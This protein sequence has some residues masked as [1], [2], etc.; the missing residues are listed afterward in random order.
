MARELILID[1][2]NQGEALPFE[3]TIS[4]HAD[5]IVDVFV[6]SLREWFIRNPIYTYVPR[7]DSFG[8]DFEL[9]NIVIVDKYTEEALFLPCIT[10]NFNGGTTKWLQF[11]H[12]PFNTVLKYQMNKDGSVKRDSAGRPI[13]SHYEYT[14]S[15]ETSITFNISTQDTL[16]REELTNYVTVALSEVCRDDLMLRGIFIRGVNAGSQ[17]EVEYRE[18]HIFQVAITAEL[19]TEWKRMIPLG[20]TLKSIGFDMNVIDSNPEPEAPTEAVEELPIYTLENEFYVVDSISQEPIIPELQ[21]SAMNIEAPI[22]LIYNPSTSRWEVSS[23]WKQALMQSMIPYG[24]FIIELTKGSASAEYLQYA[25]DAI[26]KAE[27]LRALSSTQGRALPDGTKVLQDCFIFTD[28]TVDIRLKQKGNSKFASAVV[29]S[30]NDVILKMIPT[31]KQRNVLIAKNVVVDAYGVVTGGQIFKRITTN[32]TIN[33]IQLSTI[34][35][36]F[37]VGENFNTMT[38]VD[39]FM[40]MQFAQQPFRYSL[41]A[42]L[43]E[44]DELLTELADMSVTVTYRANKITSINNIKQELVARSEKFLLQQPIGL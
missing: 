19:Y 28:G 6:Q 27:S 43:A 44:I 5:V 41:A 31:N 16:S 33:D 24:N 15:Y 32:N 40:I 8:P 20:D 12:S 9:T 36:I 2:I 1:E 23:F 4:T 11:S 42:I 35:Q 25:A 34:D 38:A 39:L 30:N 13:P 10:V 18:N 17:T 37:L 29:Q 3:I 21:L 7:E 14:G 26:V 22:T